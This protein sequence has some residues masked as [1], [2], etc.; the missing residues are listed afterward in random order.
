MTP[1]KFQIAVLGPQLFLK[2]EYSAKLGN[3]PIPYLNFNQKKV[4]EFYT[5]FSETDFDDFRSEYLGEN[6]AMCE[7][8]LTCESGP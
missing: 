3:I 1:L 2:R 4:E 8:A 6:E 5:S 7:T